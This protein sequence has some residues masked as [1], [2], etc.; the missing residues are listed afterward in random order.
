MIRNELNPFWIRPN[1]NWKHWNN[2]SVVSVHIKKD[3]KRIRRILSSPSA[4]KCKNKNLWEAKVSDEATDVLIHFV[5]DRLMQQMTISQSWNS[6]T[7]IQ[8]T[9]NSGSGRNGTEERRRRW[10]FRMSW[11]QYR[12]CILHLEILNVASYTSW[13]G[14]AYKWL[15]WTQ[16]SKCLQKDLPRA[17]ISKEFF[18]QFEGKEIF[19][20][21]VSTEWRSLS[22]A[23]SRESYETSSYDGKSIHRLFGYWRDIFSTVV[24]WVD[25]YEKR[26]RNSTLILVKT[27]DSWFNPDFPNHVPEVIS[28]LHSWSLRIA[29][30]NTF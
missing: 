4:S 22:Y 21:L 27:V 6:M 12:L 25:G 30:E 3:N 7:R 10:S 15:R 26:S 2:W 18:D 9:W 13:H 17:Q 20:D 8:W 14:L 28:D 23:K 29:S 24:G 5:C 1:L 19:A 16:T 11:T